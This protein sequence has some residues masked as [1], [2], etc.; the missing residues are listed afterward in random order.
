[1]LVGVPVSGYGAFL[2]AAGLGYQSR[3]T[4][5]LR[6]SSDRRSKVEMCSAMALGGH[7]PEI[8]GSGGAA[9]AS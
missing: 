6:P 4:S 3:S 7:T 9:M 2:R 1:M 5:C 8:R